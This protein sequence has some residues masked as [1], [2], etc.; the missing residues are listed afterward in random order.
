MKKSLII[1]LFALLL[2][3]SCQNGPGLVTPVA[4]TRFET[5]GDQYVSYSSHKYF[6]QL[7]VWKN[8]AES[9][10]QFGISDLSFSFGECCGADNL[11]G[12]RYTLVKMSSCD[13]RVVIN[14]EVYD[15]SKSIYLNG[16]ALVPDNSVTYET[17]TTLEF[18]HPAFVRTNPGGTVDKNKV[19]VLEYK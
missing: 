5:T 15:S 18:N 11:E 7:V 8:K 16:T 6:N 3:T 2:F 1:V 12:K 9:E 14:S 19:N 4:Y 17:F 10:A 13:F